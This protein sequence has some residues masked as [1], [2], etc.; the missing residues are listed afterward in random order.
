[1]NIKI[2]D[3]ST[4][5]QKVYVTVKHEVRGMPLEELAK[6]LNLKK[7]LIDYHYAV[8]NEYHN[9]DDIHDAVD[10]VAERIA[11]YAG[12]DDDFYE[13]A[14]QLLDLVKDEVIEEIYELDDDARDI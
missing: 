4:P 10:Y 7:E 9:V 6:K 14:E 8:C 2:K 1:M 13:L 5:K 3:N 12:S 11:E